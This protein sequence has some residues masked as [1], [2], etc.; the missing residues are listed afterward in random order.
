MVQI[1]SFDDDG[2]GGGE[3]DF[4]MAVS[5]SECLC[6][7]PST[8][9]TRRDT[10]VCRLASACMLSR[11]QTSFC[12]QNTNPLQRVSTP[13]ESSEV[14]GMSVWLFEG[15]FIYLLT[16]ITR[17]INL[18]FAQGEKQVNRFH[19]EFQLHVVEGL[20]R[21]EQVLSIVL[22]RSKAFD[23]VHHATLL[24]QLWSSELNPRESCKDAF[25]ELGLLTLPCLYILEV[26][27]YCRLKCELV[28]G[29]D[30]HQYGTRGR[31]NFRVQQHRTAA[32]EHLPS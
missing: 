24:H 13:K 32:F 9:S 15:C 8:S 22:D 16:S 30:V 6:T 31:D 14:S 2:D 20:E 21:R 23:C 12:G 19:N 1:K 7:A 3:D 29:M 4:K 27:L 25:R 18:K 17:L 11:A 5:T 28:R 26:A 10:A